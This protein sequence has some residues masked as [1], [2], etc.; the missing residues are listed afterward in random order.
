[1]PSNPTNSTLSDV[2]NL[3]NHY[4]QYAQSA[5]LAFSK[6]RQQIP[7]NTTASAQYSLAR[8]CT[9]CDIAYK[10]W[11]CAVTIPRCED[12]SNDDMSLIPR[13]VNYS[14]T[15][16]SLKHFESDPVF[17][18]ENK[19]Y[20]YFNSSRH[21]PIDTDIMP[22]PYKE[23]LPCETLCHE[24]VQSCPAALQFSCPLKDFG[25]N[26]TYGK[27]YSCNSL[28]LVENDAR[29]LSVFGVLGRVALVSSIMFVSAG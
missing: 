18:A 4:D 15:N 24:L 1:M 25:L 3:A 17:S 5:W 20:R 8:N 7:C 16:A 11:L 23:R 21:E 2:T 19:T 13:A 14:F 22:G 29:R 28:K 9:D 27:R 26:F 12:Y 10:R 6:S